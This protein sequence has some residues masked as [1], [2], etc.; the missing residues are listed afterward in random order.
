MVSN[1]LRTRAIADAKTK[2]DTI[3][4]A[5]LAELMAA[6]YLPEVWQPDPATQAV[7]RRIAAR[8]ALVGLRTRLRNRIS[9]IL[10][11]NL[12]A[13]PWSDP[14]GRSGRRWFATVALPADEHEGVETSLQLLDALEA[15]IVVAEQGLARLVAA[16]PRVRRLMTIP[17][18]GV[19]TAI[20]L[21]ACIGDVGR[22]P[23]RTSS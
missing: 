5:T 4:A 20:G 13:N 14:F 1:S 7:R 18:V 15:E 3:D 12:V 2:T 21:V 11:R 8:A 23:G 9:A 19:M 17:G 6:D 10:A 16:D 22:F